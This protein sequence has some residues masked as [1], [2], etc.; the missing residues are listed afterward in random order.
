MF[1]V[2][3]LTIAIRTA[4]PELFF[5]NARQAPPSQPCEGFQ[6]KDN[7]GML[8]AYEC[9]GM[10][11]GATRQVW[12]YRLLTVSLLDDLL[13]GLTCFEQNGLSISIG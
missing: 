3:S 6:D 2:Q 10:V 5:G 1:A 13:S 8:I 12:R 4:E 9:R 7:F 11:Q